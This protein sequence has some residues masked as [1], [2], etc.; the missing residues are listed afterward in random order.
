[1][2]NKPLTFYDMKAKKPFETDK[3]SVITERGRRVAITTAPSGAR[4][5]SFM[6]KDKTE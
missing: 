2:A 5:R 3:Y 6:P 4:A 1:M